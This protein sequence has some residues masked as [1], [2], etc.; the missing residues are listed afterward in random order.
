MGLIAVDKT[1]VGGVIDTP[2]GKGRTHVVTFSGVVVNHIQNYFNASLMQVF[3][4]SLELVDLMAVLPIG[5]VTIVR[6]KETNG[7]VTPVVTQALVLQTGVID[8][9]VHRH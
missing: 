4:H 3:N 2:E 9:L 5:G 7:V 8:E 6:G 1:V